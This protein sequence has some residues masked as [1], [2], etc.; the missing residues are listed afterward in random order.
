MT[1]PLASVGAGLCAIG[2]SL[3]LGMVVSSALQSIARQPELA[4]KI[5]VL[6]FIGAALIEGFALFAIVICFLQ[7]S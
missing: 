1:L 5:Q 3:G 4:P 7:M 6:M 2:A